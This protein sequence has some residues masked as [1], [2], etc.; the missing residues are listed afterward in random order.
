MHLHERALQIEIWTY[1]L[2]CRRQRRHLHFY[3][4]RQLRKAAT[5]A[6]QLLQLPLMPC[7]TA[8]EQAAAG[9]Q[10]TL[11]C[12]GCQENPCNATASPRSPI[13][14]QPC[15]GQRPQPQPPGSHLAG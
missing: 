9:R 12:C 4:R 14:Q 13:A 5:A 6:Q 2:H 15:C 1:P 8:P 7:R 10:L 3:M 11:S